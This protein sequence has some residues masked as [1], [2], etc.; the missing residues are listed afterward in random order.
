MT[1]D[2][3]LA[4]QDLVLSQT[5]ELLNEGMGKLKQKI[6][7]DPTLKPSDKEIAISMT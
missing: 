3:I 7:D 4:N 6:M 2:Y 1:P 5:K